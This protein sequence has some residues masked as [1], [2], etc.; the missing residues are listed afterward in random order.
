M[1]SYS[2]PTESSMTP[3]G[4]Q[5]HGGSDRCLTLFVCHDGR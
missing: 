5:T 2:Q 1:T 4:G 3:R